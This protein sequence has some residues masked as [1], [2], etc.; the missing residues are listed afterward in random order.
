MPGISRLGQDSAGG[1]IL[2]GGNGSVFANGTI[3]AVRGS[4][5]AGHGSPP[6]SGP[7]MVCASGTVYAQ[8]IA[9]CRAGDCASCGHVATGSGNVFAG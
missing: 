9:V 4:G 8:G 5:V 6:H 3:V 2:S 7:V 1:T